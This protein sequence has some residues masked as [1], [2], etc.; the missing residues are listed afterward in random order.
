VDSSVSFAVLHVTNTS[1]KVS[2][3]NK[4]HNYCIFFYN[5]IILLNTK[6]YS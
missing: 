1:V 6:C 4:R 2:T 3:P 5:D